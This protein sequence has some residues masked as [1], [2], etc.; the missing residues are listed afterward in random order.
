MLVLGLG[1]YAYSTDL[2]HI[3][4]NIQLWIRGDQT[5][6]V[7]EVEQ[8]DHS[9]YTITYQDAEGNTHERSG[10]G[11][12]IEPFGRERPLTEE[13]ILS[14]LDM[15]EVEYLEDG[16]A[17]VYFRD[18]RVEITDKFDEDGVCRVQVTDGEQTHYMTIQY[19]SGYRTDTKRFPSARGLK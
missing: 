10:G 2:G 11:I 16:T 19:M 1:G 13:E 8:T 15:P 18:Q 12:A 14:Q 9:E 3:Q 5:D 4:R 7:L 17:W 6:A